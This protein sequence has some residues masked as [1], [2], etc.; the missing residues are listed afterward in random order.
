MGGNLTGIHQFDSAENL[1]LA[2]FYSND[3][4]DL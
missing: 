4:R 2:D 1:V 3:L